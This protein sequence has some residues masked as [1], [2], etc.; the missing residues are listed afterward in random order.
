M[1][2]NKQELIPIPRSEFMKLCRDHV[3]AVNMVKILTMICD[4]KQISLVLPVSSYCSI[5]KIDPRAIDMA[6]QKGWI[7]MRTFNNMQ[8]LDAFDM[9][10][11]AEK[12]QR[13]SRNRRIQ[14]IRPLSQ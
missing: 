6:V 5:L 3:R 7:K 1:N 9:A 4:I 13:R 2:T 10:L 11:L 14:R 8:V 12:L